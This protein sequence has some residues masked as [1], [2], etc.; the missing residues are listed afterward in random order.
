MLK[1]LNPTRTLSTA[2]TLLVTDIA[3]SQPLRASSQYPVVLNSDI[4]K[5]VCYMQT[6]D[7]GTLDLS[8]LC[9][10]APSVPAPTAPIESDELQRGL[11]PNVSVAQSCNSNSGEAP[12]CIP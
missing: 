5:P 12:L 4:N 7:G 10:K 6:P 9:G 11:D 3:F 1:C 2:L 8:S